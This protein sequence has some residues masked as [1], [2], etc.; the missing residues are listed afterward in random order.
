[1]PLSPSRAVGTGGHQ[2]T[3]MGV[4][5]AERGLERGTFGTR[6]RGSTE[7]RRAAPV[8]D[9]SS[10]QN[11]RHYRMRSD[12]A[13]S[14]GYGPFGMMPAALVNMERAAQGRLEMLQT[15]AGDALQQSPRA[16]PE[17]WAGGAPRH[18]PTGIADHTGIADDGGT[19][20]GS[21]PR[22]PLP[23]MAEHYARSP[24]GLVQQF[25]PDEAA[26]PLRPSDAASTAQ[27][28]LPSVK[29][30]G[31]TAS[32]A[33]GGIPMRELTELSLLRGQPGTVHSLQQQRDVSVSLSELAALEAKLA[34][35]MAALGRMQ[36]CN[37]SPRL[38]TGPTPALAVGASPRAG[39]RRLSQEAE[40]LMAAGTVMRN[41]EDP[42]MHWEW[43]RPA[44]TDRPRG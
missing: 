16:L 19:A 39:R 37:H 2:T 44:V 42:T 11:A 9:D 36:S 18:R 40:R 23:P 1:M 5:V 27:S 4:P 3:L 12:V 32:G 14:D 41:Y 30:A 21:T 28:Q 43:H 24:R 26:W 7:A 20:I 17:W 10:W 22:Y 33:S 13:P 35:K 31:A 15:G 25:T 6:A 38:R 29:H 34:N 8:V